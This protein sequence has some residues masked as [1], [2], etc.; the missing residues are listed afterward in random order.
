MLKQ[1]PRHFCPRNADKG[2]LDTSWQLNPKLIQ[3]FL[4]ILGFENQQ[5]EYHYQIYDPRYRWKDPEKDAGPV[6]LPLYTLVAHRP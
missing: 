6:Y 5:L 2:P 3:E 4:A 1:H